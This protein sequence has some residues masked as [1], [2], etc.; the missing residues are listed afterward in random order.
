MEIKNVVNEV[1]KEYPKMEQV[2]KRHL[3]K[4]IPSKW[5]KVGFSSL[6]IAM[7]MKNKVSAVS[8]SD[9]NAIDIAGG[10]TAPVPAPVQ[11]PVYIQICNIVSSIVLI[12][13]AVASIITG[14]SM[15]ITKMK[16]KKVEKWVKIVFIIYIIIFILSILIKFIMNAIE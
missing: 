1:E 12:V 4:S 11:V 7:I 6:V 8:L 13:S 2:C 5:I 3:A 9:F 16:S 15:L 14:L 10:F